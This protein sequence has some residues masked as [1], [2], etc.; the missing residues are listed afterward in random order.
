MVPCTRRRALHG[1][2]GL[3]TALAGCSGSSS[4]SDRAGGPVTAENV[5]MEPE[6]L[7]LRNPQDNP[8][9]WIRPEDAQ[10]RTSTPTDADHRYREYGLI[11]TREKAD[12]IAFADIDGID[13]AKTFVD[14]TDFETE[15]LLLEPDRIGEC[16]TL[17]LCYITWSATEYHTYYARLYRDVDVACSTENHDRV[18]HFIRIPD[19]L[20]PEKVRGSGSGTTSGT[21]HGWQRRLER[22]RVARSGAPGNETKRDGTTTEAASGG[23]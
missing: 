8:A 2:A 21:C 10:E 13:S 12:R 1:A 22:R 6:R 23:H 17:K 4:G 11:A 14:E 15:T 5:E 19:T 20:D 3:L 7:D 9:A 16:F 18:A